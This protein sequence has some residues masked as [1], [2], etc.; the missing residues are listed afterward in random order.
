NMNKKPAE[1]QMQGKETLSY[2]YFAVAYL[3]KD[4]NKEKAK[5]YALKSVQLN[6]EYKDA[7][8]LLKLLSQ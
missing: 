6:P 5:E 4:K 3:E 2:A 1:E 8:N 7:Q